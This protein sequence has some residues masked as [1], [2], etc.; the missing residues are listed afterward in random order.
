MMA[1]LRQVHVFLRTQRLVLRR[2]TEADADDLA[3]LNSDPEVMR[4]LA[5]GAATTPDEVRDKI[6]P[7]QLDCYERFGGL[8]LWAADDRNSGEFLGWFH[9]RPRRSDGVI[10]LGYRLRRQTW[11]LGLATEGSRALIDK[12]FTELGMDR[13]TAETMAVNRASRRVMEKCGMTLA[14]TFPWDGTEPVEG[15]EQGCV[16]Y[17]LTRHEWQHRRDPSGPGSMRS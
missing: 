9:L 10:D 4:Y 5:G 14:R 11:G 13:I 3:R 17:A 6:I 2:L 1:R 12:G 16:E 7:Y 15:A 8:G